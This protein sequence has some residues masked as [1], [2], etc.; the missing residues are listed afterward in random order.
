MENA[1]HESRSLKLVGGNTN[2]KRAAARRYCAELTAS[3]QRFTNGAEKSLQPG[4]LVQWKP[5]MKNRKTPDYDE[6]MVVMDVLKQPIIDAT[7]ESGSVYYREPL[8]ILLGFFDE[9]GDF[10]V[11]HYDSH[12]FAPYAGV[13]AE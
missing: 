2:E 11:L 8:D 1:T 5:G 4:M 3:F 12:R 6:P 9:D 10:G 7:F 13:D